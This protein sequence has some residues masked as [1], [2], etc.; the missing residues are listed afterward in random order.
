MQNNDVGAYLIGAVVVL[1][2]ILGLF[3]ASLATDRI[4]HFSGL[5]LF[6]FM[7]LFG[8]RLIAQVT[9]RKRRAA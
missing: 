4:F 6:V 7:V 9:G 2:A 8:F 5:A 1:L 3:M